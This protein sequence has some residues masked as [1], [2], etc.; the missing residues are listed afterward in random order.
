MDWIQSIRLAVEYIEANL[1]EDITVSDIAKH[2]CISPY[3][4][5]KGFS[6]VCGISV[7]EYIRKRRLALAAAD[8]CSGK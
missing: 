6:A 1:C 4:F 5:Q 2:A 3:Y 8:L 7:K